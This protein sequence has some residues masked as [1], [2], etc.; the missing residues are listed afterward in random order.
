M[1]R[2]CLLVPCCSGIFP[3][4]Y[5]SYHSLSGLGGVFLNEFYSCYISGLFPVHDTFFLTSYS[6]LY[7]WH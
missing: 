7:S 1:N 2:A 4:G 6:F 5:Y 3:D